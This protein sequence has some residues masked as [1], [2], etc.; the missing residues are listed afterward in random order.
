MVFPSHG[1]T[2]NAVLL[3]LWPFAALSSWILAPAIV[4]IIRPSANG[5]ATTF[6]AR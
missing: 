3:L 2:L 6:P 1:G 4:T 5:A